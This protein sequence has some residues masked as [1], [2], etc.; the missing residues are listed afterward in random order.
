MLRVLYGGTFDPVHAG[1][2]AV[3]HAAVAAFGATVH[4][5]PAADPPHRAPPGASA[6]QRAHMVALAIG[7]DPQLALDTREL[8]RGGPSYTVL[9]LRDLRQELGP[10]A[11]LAWLI[12]ADAFCGLPTWHDWTA[13]FDLAHFAV[14][15]RPGSDPLS[16]P[17]PLQAACVGRWTR[18]ARDLEATPAGC[19]FRLEMAPHPAS[20]SAIRAALRAGTGDRGWLPAP[21]ADYIRA[22]GLYGPGV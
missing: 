12:G 16:L 18:D 19:L 20:A 7:G 4:F 2:L 1:H 22:Q 10:A 15:G 5:L 6:A 9:S 3:A 11:P 8:R 21:V 13:L 14:V 17:E